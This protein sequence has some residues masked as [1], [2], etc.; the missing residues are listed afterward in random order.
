MHIIILIILTNNNNSKTRDRLMSYLCAL[1][2][3]KIYLYSFAYHIEAKI[4]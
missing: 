4:N 1:V 2:A 3:R